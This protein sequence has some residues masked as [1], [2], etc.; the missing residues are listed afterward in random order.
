RTVDYGHYR[1]GG[2][3]GSRFGGQPVCNNPRQVP[4]ADLDE[5]VWKDVCD[6]LRNPAKVRAE[7]ERRRDQPAGEK[8]SLQAA[9]VTKQI[10]K[11]KQAIARLIDAYQEGVLDKQEF[12]P[13][14]RAAKDRLAGLEEEAR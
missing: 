13:R 11:V 14:L 6:L 7:Y 1:C 12:A 8:I 9:Q 2:R 10:H 3:N 4:V 5:A